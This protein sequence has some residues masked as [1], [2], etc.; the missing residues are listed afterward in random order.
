MPLKRQPDILEV[1]GNLDSAAVFTPPRLANVI[2]DLLPADVW[3]D[4]DLRWL[5]PACK[6]GVFLREIAKRLMVGLVDAFPEEERRQ[7]ILTQMLYGIATE[8][9]TAMMTRRTLYCS[10]DASSVHSVARFPAAAG[11]IWWRRVEH[12]FSDKGT[13]MECK[14][15]QSDLEKAGRDNKAYAPIHSLGRVALGEDWKN[16]KFDVIVGNPPYQMKDGGYL[17]SAS[18]LYNFFVD[19]ALSLDPEHVAMIIPSRWFVGGKGL[20]EFRARMLQDK[21]LRVIVDFQ[22]ARVVFPSINLN[23]GVCY[24]HWSKDHEGSCQVT[25]NSVGLSPSTTVR[26]LG[27]FDI[28]IRLNGAVEVVRRVLARA[29]PSFEQK[30]STLRPFGL[31]TY[32]RG[33]EAPQSDDAVLLYQNGGIGWI[34]RNKIE[35]NDEWIDSYKVLIPR[36]TDGNEN[37]PLPVLTEPIIAEPGSACTETYLVLGPCVTREEAMNLVAYTKTRFFRFL[38]GQR[39]HTQDNSRD[40]FRFIPDLALDQKWTDDKLYDRYGITPEERQLIAAQIKEML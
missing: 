5:D 9:L 37:Y 12:I 21:H 3:R 31:R 23:G 40:K 2:L 1:F 30:V 26:R 17:A 13:C 38:L 39:K 4:P 16:M 18:P 24:F 7:H 20:D 29:E 14:G 6:S 11:N 27:E 36:A 35:M 10:K 15:Q 22:D 28:L 32:F 25:S 34:D 8:E 19:Y 33:N